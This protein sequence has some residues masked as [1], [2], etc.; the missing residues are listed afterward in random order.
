MSLDTAVRLDRPATEAEALFLELE[1]HGSSVLMIVP[2]GGRPYLV[3]RSTTIPA[4][5]AADAVAAL[6]RSRFYKE[7]QFQRDLFGWLYTEGAVFQ[8]YA[9]H[10]PRII[11][12]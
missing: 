2:P 5:P 8:R 7:P 6:I 9:E 12:E 1:E 4:A 11:L 10:Q 3:F